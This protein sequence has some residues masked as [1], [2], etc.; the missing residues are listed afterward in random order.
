MSVKEYFSKWYQR[1][2]GN[3][4]A[5]IFILFLFFV[6]T[7]IYLFGNILLPLLIALVLA[8]LLEWPVG[9]LI[10][11][12]IPRV[13][14]IVV[15]FSLFIGLL[16]MA[17]LLGLPVL[18]Q[19]LISLINNFPE[20]FQEGKKL[21]VTLQQ[22]Y[23][24]AVSNDQLLE[25]VD[26]IKNAGTTISKYLLSF[27]I[28]SLSNIIT[29][30]LYLV[31]VPI[32][33]FFLLKDKNLFIAQ[34]AA[35]MPKESSLIYNVFRTVHI[36]IGN[37]IYGKFLEAFIVG[38]ITFLC[39]VYFKLQY[40]ALL[41][42]LVALSVFFPYI[43]TVIVTL[44]VVLTGIFQMGL[45]PQFGHLMLFYAFIQILDGNVL[46]P[47]LLSDAT[48]MHPIIIILSIILFGGLFGF[49]GIFFA[50]PLAILIHA[51]IK[52]WPA[53]Q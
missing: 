37:Y 49:W 24:N 36:G 48:N 39:F 46:V 33:A 45:S 34:G 27:S 26:S 11:I 35:I 6:I 9:W 41:G 50:I 20:M 25:I 28:A 51:V 18:K 4:E 31:L 47:M 29:V 10:K 3:I 53:Y 38:F 12:G 32:L 1:H 13:L 44:P 17:V 15:I 16:V 5:V 7:V 19:Q 43:G 30:V 40:A 14:A 22:Q 23:P 8:Y 21:L 2:L 52:S 42:F